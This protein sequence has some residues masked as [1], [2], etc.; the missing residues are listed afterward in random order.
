MLQTWPLSKT[1]DN[2]N[3]LGK[4]SEIL[5]LNPNNYFITS[6]IWVNITNNEGKAFLGSSSLTLKLHPQDC[7]IVLWLDLVDCGTISKQLSIDFDSNIAKSRLVH[8]CARNVF[9]A[10]PHPLQTT[11]RKTKIQTWINDLRNVWSKIP[12]TLTENMVFIAHSKKL[13]EKI[14][15]R[16]D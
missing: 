4:G 1:T 11:K 9:P 8:A 5:L 7:I 13:T 16:G 3:S 14:W 10:E 15:F 6:I 12:K 2:S